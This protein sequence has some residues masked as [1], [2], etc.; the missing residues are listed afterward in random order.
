M[1]YVLQMKATD[2]LRFQN[3]S[4]EQGKEPH[5]GRS[6]TYELSI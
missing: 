3:I 1:I 4:A 2:A 6:L 5:H